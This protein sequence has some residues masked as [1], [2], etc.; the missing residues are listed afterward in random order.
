M[1][2]KIDKTSIDFS[3]KKSSTFLY[4]DFLIIQPGGKILLVKI[5]YRRL[6]FQMWIKIQELDLFR[7]VFEIWI[8][9]SRKKFKTP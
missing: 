5:L 8:S 1:Y 6:R 3:R 2:V 7:Q 4:E 9:R